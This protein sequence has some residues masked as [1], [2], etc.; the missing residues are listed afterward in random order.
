MLI[1]FYSIIN[2][3]SSSKSYYYLDFNKHVEESNRKF[4]EILAKL[5]ERRKILEEYSKIIEELAKEVR[6]LKASEIH[7]IGL[8]YEKVT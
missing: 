6:E 1:K 3:I 4:N 5:R 2:F 8:L 7:R